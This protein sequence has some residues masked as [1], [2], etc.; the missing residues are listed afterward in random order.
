MRLLPGIVAIALVA[1]GLA[2]CGAPVART[3][4]LRHLGEGE[5]AKAKGNADDLWGTSHDEALGR[6]MDRGMLD[7]LDGQLTTS[8]Q[9]LDA[10]APLVDDF[11]KTTAG[12]LVATA[13]LNDSAGFFA[14]APFEHTQLDWYRS[15]NHLLT[16][17]IADNIWHPPYLLAA[18][19]PGA[20]PLAPEHADPVKE[21]ELAIIIA[22]RMTLNQLQETADAA[23]KDYY[24]DDPFAR[25]YAG[26]AV[27]AL[28]PRERTEAD[29]QFATAMLKG[30]LGAYRKQAETLGK[31]GIG[32]RYEAPAAPNAAARLYLRQ[33]R[34]YDPEEYAR[35]QARLGLAP[36]PAGSGCLLVLHQAG[37]IA[38][39][40]PLQIGLLAV[41]FHTPR[42]PTPQQR[43]RGHTQ[44]QF[45]MGALAFMA[46]GPGSEIA[47]TWGVI[48]IPGSLVQQ[49]LAPG[50]ATVIGFELPAHPTDLPIAPLYPVQ[51]MDA[52]GATSGQPE[53]LADLD[54]Y[55]RA[56]LKDRQPGTLVRTLS[57]VAVKQASVAAAAHAARK[58]DQGLLAFGINLVGSALMT[59]T[60]SADLRSWSTLPDHIEGT[61]L[62]L[63]PGTVQVRLGTY[64]LG[65][66]RIEADR[67]SLV[68]L[69][70]VP[71]PPIIT[72]DHP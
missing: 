6:H 41:G 3:E 10:A 46:T 26:V 61:L 72:K 29:E 34:R 16:A 63:P 68:V 24:D 69:R 4:M 57:R 66:V 59:S 32:F 62:D 23:G 13:V 15:L 21:R 45:S 44:T 43:A 33:L 19:R 1:G 47:K 42:E 30:S 14:G 67:L 50:G 7:H 22:R 48:P 37:L 11:R 65:P 9:E 27:L 39:P 20:T 36:A 49:C 12:N 38:K 28:P 17:Q 60:E 35:E 64:D 54:A 51:V 70:T 5:P 56:N 71:L 55:A 58:N 31:T 8:N 2:G 40:E 25:F 52:P 18:Q 53:V